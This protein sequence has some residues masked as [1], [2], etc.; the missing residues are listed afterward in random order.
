V[1]EADEQIA[2]AY[3]TQQGVVQ[4]TARSSSSSKRSTR[5]RNVTAM[6]ELVDIIDVE[7][8]GDSICAAAII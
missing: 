8:V 6:E 5:C 3:W 1:D 7:V 2:A 4:T